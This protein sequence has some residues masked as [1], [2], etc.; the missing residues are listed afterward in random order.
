[1]PAL[2]QW[3]DDWPATALMAVRLASLSSRLQEGRLGSDLGT[4]YPALR[5]LTVA[6][7]VKRVLLNKA[8]YHS[9][10]SLARGLLLAF[11]LTLQREQARW[12]RCFVESGFGRKTVQVGR[13][14]LPQ[15][16]KDP[17]SRVS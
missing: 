6:V 1:M 7:S 8:G 17:R 11:E 13:C 12:G 5:G 2:C 14:G 10:T 9:T 15:T 4:N 16:V 3:G